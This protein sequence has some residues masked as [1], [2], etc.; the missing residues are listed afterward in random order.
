MTIFRPLYF[1]ISRNIFKYH[2]IAIFTG[3]K[4]NNE[5]SQRLFKHFLLNHSIPFVECRALKRNYIFELR[6][7]IEF[8]TRYNE[9]H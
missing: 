5:N 1:N 7:L 4:I 2:L 6:V 9:Q 3:S 8:Y